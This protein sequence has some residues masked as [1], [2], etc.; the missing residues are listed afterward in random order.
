MTPGS[1]VEVCVCSQ[2]PLMRCPRRSIQHKGG[3]RA[4][5]IHSIAYSMRGAI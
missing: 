2:D 3:T 1:A 4:Q 5:K